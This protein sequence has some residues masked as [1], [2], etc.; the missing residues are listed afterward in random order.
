[1]GSRDLTPGDS[2]LP[3]SL[4]AAMF[5]LR[6]LALGHYGVVGCFPPQSPFDRLTV[7]GGYKGRLQD[8][9][10]RFLGLRTLGRLLSIGQ[11]RVSAPCSPNSGSGTWIAPR[12]VAMTTFLQLGQLTCNWRGDEVDGSSGGTSH[13]LYITCTMLLLCTWNGCESR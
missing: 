9:A 1:M 7:P 11:D 10:G 2:S 13:G 4:D 12:S 5:G 6:L 8:V 3:S